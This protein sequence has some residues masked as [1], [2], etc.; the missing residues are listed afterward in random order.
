LQSYNSALQAIAAL[1]VTVC[2]AAGDNGS[3]DGV[4]DGKYHVD[5]PASSPYSLACGG[6]SLR[7]SGTKISSEV[8][9]NDGASGGATG[10]GV[11]DTFPLPSYQSKAKVPTSANKGKFKGR[12]VPDI[13]GDAD[14]ATGYKVESDG[15]S[16]AVGGTSA[17]A[18]LW[19]G[20]ITLFNQSLGKA[21]GFLNPNLYQS[22]ATTKGTFRDITS[23]NNGHFKAATGWDACTGWG[24]PI[25]TA[26]QSALG[27]LYKKKK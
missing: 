25:G 23:G 3:S 9:W 7:L 4:S 20:L 8:V 27:P 5:F 24:S 1:G 18:P 17:V 12:G 13:A 16:F 21:V 19:A 15:S 6:T 2:V 14:P 10:G 11:S 22:V 26:I